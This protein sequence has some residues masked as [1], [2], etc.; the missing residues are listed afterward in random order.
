MLQASL[1]L[2]KKAY[3]GIPKPI[4]W[5][6]F[7]MLINRSGTMVVPFL[8]VYLT[9]QGYTLSQ[10]GTVMSVFGVGAILGSFLGGKLSDRFSFFWVQFYSLILNGVFFIVLSFIT[11][12]NHFLITIFLL[13]SVGEAFRPA[14][15]A[16]IAAYS[17]DSN[18]TRA[19]SLNRLAINLGWSIGP[20]VG[21]ILAYYNYKLLFWADGLTCIAAALLLYVFLFSFHQKHHHTD[22]QLK[23]EMPDRAA[24]AYK[25]V[26]FMQAMFF[27][28]LIGTCFFRCLAC[29]RFSTK[30]TYISQ[31]KLL[32]FC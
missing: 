1:N 16:A 32:V 25:D 7:V 4:W 11:N 27:V 26:V 17:T 3:T 22:K 23:K 29:C 28:L 2:Y 10:A 6:S 5:L 8:T 12:Y 24:S 21:G 31:K 30:S 20:A 15:S 19:Y 9:Q 13:A 18:R 14:N